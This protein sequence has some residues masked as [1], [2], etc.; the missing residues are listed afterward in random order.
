M[1]TLATMSSSLHGPDN[2][3]A[4]RVSTPSSPT[5]FQSQQVHSA[6]SFI[7][8]IRGPNSPLASSSS[9]LSSSSSSSGLQ[10]TPLDLPPG[11]S[12]A[13][14]VNGW[15]DSHVARWLADIRCGSLAST[16]KAND[17]RGDVLLELDQTT[18]KEMGVVSIGDRL[19]IVNAVKHLR[20]KT[21]SSRFLPL[22]SPSPPRV[23][24][25]GTSSPISGSSP[26]FG[27]GV[28]PI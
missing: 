26:P 8:A 24:I 5:S 18:L 10:N 19:R 28:S 21:S 27:S 11:M 15:S 2:L 23:Y 7:G 20:Q 13:E 4:T 17:I 6:R 3:L 9:S 12:Y 1:S 14:F 22:Q 16:F 25:N